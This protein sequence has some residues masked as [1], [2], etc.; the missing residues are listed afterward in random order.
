MKKLNKT[1]LAAAL[2]TALVSSLGSAGV[3]AE[4]SPFGLN[5]LSGG[6]MQLAEAD[7]KK[8]EMKCGAQMKD[9]KEAEMNCGAKIGMKEGS[10]G[11]AQCGAMM[12]GEEPKM[13]EGKCAGKR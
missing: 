1:P 3:N 11:E 12:M 7:T 6:Y 5:E 13:P 8:G 10:C 9:M 4:V 2:G